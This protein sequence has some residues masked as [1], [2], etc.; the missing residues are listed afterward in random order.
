MTATKAKLVLFVLSGACLALAAPEKQDDAYGYRSQIQSALERLEKGRYRQAEQ[1]A[2]DLAVGR[3][4][5]SPNNRAWLIAAAARRRSGRYEQARQAYK[6]YLASCTSAELRDYALRQMEACRGEPEQPG[7][8]PARS[9]DEELTKQHCKRLAETDLH[10]HTEYSEHFVIYAKNAELAELVSKKAEEALKRICR[11]ILAGQEYPH[12]VDIYVWANREEYLQHAQ[13]APEWSGGNFSLRVGQD[14]TVR[15]IDLTQKNEKGEFDTIMLDR[16]LPHEMCHLVLREYF[17]DSPCPLF[18]DEG[19]AMMAENEI[20]NERL[21]LAGT[22][23]GGEDAIPLKRLASIARP[24]M[25]DPSVF[26]AESLS[27]VEYLHNKLTQKQFHQFIR[28]VRSG[29]TV[30]DAIQRALY[31]PQKEQFPVAL[32]AAWKEHAVTNAQYLRALYAAAE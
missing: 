26:Y 19:L 16:V 23:L 28:H 12:T 15:R 13:D 25:V 32:A 11:V 4:G 22:V 30:T 1:L 2:L 24:D 31:L 20:D 7:P 5:V 8:A 29:C 14:S 3:E 9:P 10:L 17:G 21:V 27:F 18:L 6:M